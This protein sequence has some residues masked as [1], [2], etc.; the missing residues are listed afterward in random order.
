MPYVNPNV[1]VDWVRGTDFS[2]YKTYAWKTSHLATPSLEPTVQG[3]ID[4]ALQ[5]KGLQKVGMGRKSQPFC[6]F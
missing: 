4:A 6:R 1:K 2:K 3:I 5:G